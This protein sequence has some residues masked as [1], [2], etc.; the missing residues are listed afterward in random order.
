[1]VELENGNAVQRKSSTGSEFGTEIAVDTDGGEYSK[2][3]DVM[4]ILP[5]GDFLNQ[6]VLDI[7]Y[8][9]MKNVTPISFKKILK[10]LQKEANG[11][12]AK[13]Y[14]DYIRT[15]LVWC[16]KYLRD[17][18]NKYNEKDMYDTILYFRGGISSSR[19][20][21]EVLLSFRETGVEVVKELTGKK[22]RQLV[23]ASRNAISVYLY[24]LYKVGI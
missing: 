22:D 4:N 9:V 5:Y 23:M 12:K 17:N 1:M 24:L 8:R 16:I 7:I 15:T 18:R 14:E 10:G 19:T 21:D 11:P 13:Y 3:N 20:T 2:I 6:D